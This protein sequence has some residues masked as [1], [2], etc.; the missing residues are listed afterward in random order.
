MQE[1]WRIRTFRDRDFLY[2][3]N[4]VQ[5]RYLVPVHGGFLDVLSRTRV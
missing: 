5:I 2:L 1:S 4:V 3:W